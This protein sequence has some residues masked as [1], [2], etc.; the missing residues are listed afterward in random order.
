MSEID[1]IAENDQLKSQSCE[2]VDPN[3][4]KDKPLKKKLKISNLNL[5]DINLSS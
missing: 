4:A 5:S 2:E 3:L 1:Q